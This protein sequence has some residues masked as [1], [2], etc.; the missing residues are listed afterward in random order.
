V[1]Y[2]AC[3]NKESESLEAFAARL[4][5]ALEADNIDRLV[6]DLRW[7]GGGNNFV[8]RPLLEAV[9]RARQNR[10]GRLFVITGPHTF[11]AAMIFAAQLERYTQ[12]I[13][14]GEPTG[15][16]PNFVGETTVVTLPNTKIAVS[17]S[18]LYW[19][20]S[21]A[22]DFRTWIPPTLYVPETFAAFRARRDS[23]LEAILAY[24]R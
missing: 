3:A 24:P 23:A 5:T 11:S 17:L 10:K 6:L 22:T 15:S 4:A 14:V 16:S 21:H 7:N 1:Q 18:N 13:F 20:T 9:I 19:Q 12:A 8:N 2:N